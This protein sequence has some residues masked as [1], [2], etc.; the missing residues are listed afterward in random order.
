MVVSNER[1]DTGAG[2]LNGPLMPLSPLLLGLFGTPATFHLNSSGAYD[3]ATGMIAGDKPTAISGPVYIES[4]TLAGDDAAGQ[5]KAT[6]KVYA[7]G[8]LFGYPTVALVILG[9]RES[10]GSL[11]KLG[12]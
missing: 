6:A 1:V 11:K 5:N 7:P 3:P 9:I 10:A 4:L 2:I 12:V 8:N